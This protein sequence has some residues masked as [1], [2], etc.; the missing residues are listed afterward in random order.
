MEL[1]EKFYNLIR[2]YVPGIVSLFI[3]LA[4]LLWQALLPNTESLGGKLLEH[5]GVAFLVTAIVILFFEAGSNEK[6]IHESLK[7][8]NQLVRGRAEE[9]MNT[10]YDLIFR[11]DQGEQPSHLKKA[12]ENLRT[13]SSYI[14]N[15]NEQRLWAKDKYI[16]FI[17]Y[18]LEDVVLRNAVNLVQIGGKGSEN[19]HVPSPAKIAEKILTLQMSAMEKGNTYD[20]VSDIS[21]WQNNQLG[22]FRDETGERVAYGVKVRR[23]FNITR[24]D[25]V[26][27]R[28]A[29]H[30]EDTF[31]INE[32]REI[33]EEHLK[34]SEAW[35]MD[36]GIPRYEVRVVGKGEVEN[37]QRR[38]YLEEQEV[39]IKHFGL[40]NRGEGIVQFTVTKPDLSDMK[41][42]T[43]LHNIENDLSV[44]NAIWYYA[45]A[46]LSEDRIDQ[47][48]QELSEVAEQRRISKKC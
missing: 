15:L 36:N 30:D 40:F 26:L 3:G 47:V 23:I 16:D 25:K 8:L 43:D 6:K 17:N 14:L 33:L 34:D 31:K 44:F 12:C 24:L 37:S 11:D 10:C 18:L 38:R 27:D 28:M 21:S 5:L 35:G 9:K 13:L 4:L 32:I 20:V 2:A 41:L 22:G 45:S 29:G 42:S 39:N 19:F 7:T 1:L 46:P 48:V